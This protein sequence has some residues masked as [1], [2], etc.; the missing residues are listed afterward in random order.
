M[1]RKAKGKH[2]WCFLGFKCNN[3][4]ATDPI[5]SETAETSKTRYL[6]GKKQQRRYSGT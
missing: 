3:V 1:V 6:E 5:A 4:D 2:E